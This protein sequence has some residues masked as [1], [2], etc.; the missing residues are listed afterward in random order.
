MAAHWLGVAA[1]TRTVK[2]LNAWELLPPGFLVLFVLLATAVVTAVVWQTMNVNLRC[3]FT[4]DA[5]VNLT[6]D[7]DAPL[8]FDFCYE[9]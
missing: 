7:R 6:V 5:T 3:P 4:L 9:K 8:K 1:E 2:R